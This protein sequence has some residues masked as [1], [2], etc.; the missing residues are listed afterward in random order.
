L[1]LSIAA[2][3]ENGKV[4]PGCREGQNVQDVTFREEILQE[5]SVF[6]TYDVVFKVA[7]ASQFFYTK[8]W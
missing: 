6:Y 8:F 4:E 1:A 2:K 5:G 7:S 3:R